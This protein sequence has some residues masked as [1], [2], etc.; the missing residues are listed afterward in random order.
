MSQETD[1]LARLQAGETLTPADAYERHG[2][3]ALHS[4]IASLRDQG[5]DIRCH[6]MTRNGKRWGCYRLRS[7]E[8]MAA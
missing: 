1:I 7:L 2:C 3:L 6:I 5:W 4:R 8:R